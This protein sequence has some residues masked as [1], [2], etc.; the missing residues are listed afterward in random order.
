MSQFLNLLNVVIYILVGLI[1]LAGTLLLGLGIGWFALDI[2]RQNQHP[3]QFQIA[4]FLG[5]IVLL[6]AFLLYSPLG[7]GGFCIGAGIA[8]IKWGFPKA[9]KDKKD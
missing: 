1:K 2:F 3:W 6:I 9:E 7:L 5:I 8:I 4:F